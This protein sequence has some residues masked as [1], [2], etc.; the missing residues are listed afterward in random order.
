MKNQI[1]PLVLLISSFLFVNTGFSQQYSKDKCLGLAI[2]LEEEVGELSPT[3]EINNSLF[4]TC[5]GIRQQLINGAGHPVNWY[6]IGPLIE[7]LTTVVQDAQKGRCS[8]A[9]CKRAKEYREEI[10]DE[11]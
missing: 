6:I 5:V 3:N 10:N 11:F 8:S 1:P 4:E 7:K 9:D 2:V